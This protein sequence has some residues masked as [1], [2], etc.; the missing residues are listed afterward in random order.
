MVGR[1]ILGIAGGAFAVAAPAY[2]SEI[3]ES[4]IRGALGSYFQLM[5]TF[6]ILLVYILGGVGVKLQEISIVCGIIPLIFGVLF[7]FMPDTPVWL[8]SKVCVKHKL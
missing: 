2:T 4:S 7:F 8:I 1:F 5:I 6:G 3:A